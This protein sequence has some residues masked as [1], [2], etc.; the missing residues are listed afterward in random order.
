MLEVDQEEDRFYA[1][2]PYHHVASVSSSS[3]MQNTML[4]RADP[5]AFQFH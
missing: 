2:P 1:V 4:R 5:L 3:M